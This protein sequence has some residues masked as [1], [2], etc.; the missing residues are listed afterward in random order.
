MLSLV[1]GPVYRVNSPFKK[2]ETSRTPMILKRYRF[3]V[4]P[5]DLLLDLYN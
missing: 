5:N 2:S 3:L 4:T 1:H